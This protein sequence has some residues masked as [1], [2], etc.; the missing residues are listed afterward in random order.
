MLDPHSFVLSRRGLIA[1]G[2]GLTAVSALPA[3]AQASP[4]V[5]T[6]A[7]RIEGLTQKGIKVFKGVRYGA[8]TAGANRFQPPRPPEPWA[9]VTPATDYAA[10][11]PQPGRPGGQPG[12]PPSEDCLFL[13][14]WTPAIDGQK[15][16]VMVWV[17]G[18]GF[19]KGSGSSPWYD[20]VNLAR[21]QDVVVVTLNHR[22]TVAGYCPLATLA[23]DRF[24]DSANVG[25]LDIVQAL[26]WV[27]D[28]IER[29]GG[30]PRRVLLF[31]QSGGGRKVSTLLAQAPAKGLFQRVAVMSGSQLRLDTP[32]S[33]EARALALL[34]ALGLPR[35]DL[36]RLVA[37]PIDDLVAASQIAAKAQGDFRPVIDGRSLTRHP[38]DPDAPPTAHDIPMIIGTTRT[39]ASATLSREPGVRDLDDAALAAR[40][41]NLV[42]PDQ[43]ARVAEAYRAHYPEAT[44]EERL[45]MAAT[46]R[47]HFLDACL[48]A[49][50]K[51]EQAGA[52]VYVYGYYRETPVEGGRL[53]APHLSDVPVVFDNTEAA[54]GVIGPS[55]PALLALASRMSAAWAAFARDGRPVAAGTPAWPAY[56][57]AR[58][59]TLIWD[60]SPRVEN[61]PRRDQRLMMT[62]FG[63]QQV[64]AQ[65]VR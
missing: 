40:L 45:Y 57:L 5:E 10:S 58:R 34:S 31:G 53:H 46:D 9:G 27:R 63:S 1:A 37:A 12:A 23:P 65:P 28:N 41:S 51:V 22:L 14:V 54:E 26:A 52:P 59:P 38:F 64:E 19:A 49:Q 11:S 43:A 47:G 13:N 39:E 3:C 20:G 7:G 4:I 48:Q 55:T 21:T 8:S 61:D 30:D 29:F 18:G 33:G 25:Q 32:E 60:V 17:H 62:A 6:T 44:N 36:D 56:D 50:R 2:V 24:A 16:P 15:R 35:A 42:P